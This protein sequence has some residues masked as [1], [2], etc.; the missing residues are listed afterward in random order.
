MPLDFALPTLRQ[1]ISAAL[2]MSN[3]QALVA[4]LAAP[5][6]PQTSLPRLNVLL[7]RNMDGR[8][9]RYV[10]L[11]PNWTARPRLSYVNAGHNPPFVLHRD[12][13]LT[14]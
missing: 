13:T 3:L 9:V 4:G 11:T 2:L 10:F 5:S 7:H 6:L 8:S 1:R 14:A 12:G